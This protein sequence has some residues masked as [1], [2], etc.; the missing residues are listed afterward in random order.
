MSLSWIP[1][2]FSTSYKGYVVDLSSGGKKRV[3]PSLA[4]DGT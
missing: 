2:A 4:L 3:T 1:K